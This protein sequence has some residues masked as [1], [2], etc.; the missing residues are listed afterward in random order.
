[1]FRPTSLFALAGAVVFGIIIADALT[2]PA[3]VTAIT[4]GVVAGEKISANALL[5]Q[6][7]N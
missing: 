2:H 3:G 7:T 6:T 4:N 1:M 5:G